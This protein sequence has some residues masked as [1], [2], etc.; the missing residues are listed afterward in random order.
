MTETTSVPQV[1]QKRFGLV[2][3][4]HWIVNH[5]WSFWLGVLAFL[6]SV[7]EAALPYIL[8]APEQRADTTSAL[9]MAFV[10]GASLILRFVAQREIGGED[11]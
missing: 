1:R 5:A 6:F 2:H 4:W 3:D 11:G 10:T 9:V 7:A 8:V